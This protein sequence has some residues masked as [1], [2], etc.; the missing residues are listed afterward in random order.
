MYIW[1]LEL[2]ESGELVSSSGDLS[3][4]IWRIE[5]N[6]IKYIKSLGEHKYQAFT[7]LIKD[8]QIVSGAQDGLKKYDIH[9]GQ[10]VSMLNTKFNIIC[11]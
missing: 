9:S 5:N 2:T 7:F 3:I 4:K 6:Q 10:N 1:Q 11:R 8:K